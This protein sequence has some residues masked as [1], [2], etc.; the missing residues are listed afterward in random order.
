[1][2]LMKKLIEKL[3]NF[4]DTWVNTFEG[5]CWGVF[6]TILI[7]FLQQDTLAYVYCGVLVGVCYV[8]GCEFA[9]DAVP[10]KRSVVML[11]EHCSPAIGCLLVIAT[12]TKHILM[13]CG[14]T[15]LSLAFTILFTYLQKLGDAKNPSQTR[16]SFLITSDRLC[17][18]CYFISYVFVDGDGNTNFGN[19]PNVQTWTPI[20]F[21]VIR[22]IEEHLKNINQ[23]PNV[24]ILN[25]ILLRKPIK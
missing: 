13:I 14:C 4:W 12:F 8:N 20:S 21:K 10:F 24:V 15:A 16:P 22:E 17:R 25:C 2:K 1:M 6:P 23:V 3:R 18:Y 19:C 9:Y 5:L 11:L 7:L